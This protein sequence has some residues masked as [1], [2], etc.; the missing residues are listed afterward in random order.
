MDLTKNSDNDRGVVLFT[1]LMFVLIMSILG[2]IACIITANDSAT[3]LNHEVSRKAFY[4]AEAGVH[5]A[6]ASIQKDLKAAAL[7]LPATDGDAI[8][9]S[10]FLMSSDPD[11][12][13]IRFE[14]L[15]TGA[16]VLTRIAA[17][18]YQFAVRG[19][20]YR[21]ADA[22]IRAT[23]KNRSAFKFGAFGNKG[24][25]APEF[26]NFYGYDSSVSLTPVGDDG[27]N[28]CDIG[29]NQSVSLSGNTEVHGHIGLGSAETIA[30]VYNP[31]GTP[32]PRI[33]GTGNAVRTVGRV[34]PDPLGI[35]GGEYAEKLNNCRIFG[36]NRT[37]PADLI[38]GIGESVTLVGKSGGANY[39]FTNIELKTGATLNI[40]TSAGPVN[41]FISGGL[42]GKNGTITHD[43][44]DPKKFAILSD[45]SDPVSL[46]NSSAFYGVVY[47]PFA[48]LDIFN[49]AAIYGAILAKTVD[50][51]NS[52]N[53]YFDIA[54][55]DKYLTKD[56]AMSS[57]YEIRR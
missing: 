28:Q 41:L 48:D 29:S 54:L 15:P 18:T 50:V 24:I 19:Y 22:D 44:G 37:I 56:V 20:S 51:K 42:N 25:T 46:S 57:W 36:D 17:N 8:S 40:D 38:L 2:T 12:T 35:V 34:E 26:S 53:F 13:D 23:F 45:R 31:T 4:S 33:Y 27:T 7:V 52:G 32:E 16:P 43:S 21:N 5:F 47:V 6:L 10:S 39:Y 9:L 11:I 30:A 14:Y 3:A 55:K 1:A 49:H